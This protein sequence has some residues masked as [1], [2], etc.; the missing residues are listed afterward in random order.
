MK[1]INI[2]STAIITTTSTTSTTTTTTTTTTTSHITS[3]SNVNNN[4]SSIDSIITTD[5]ISHSLSHPHR[6][7]FSKDVDVLE[8][9]NEKKKLL[10]KKS[11]RC[12][13][14]F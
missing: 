14:I 1:T 8:I 11:K 12:C 4:S 9:E 5:R 10:A 6:V 7:S 3:N 13:I 2:N